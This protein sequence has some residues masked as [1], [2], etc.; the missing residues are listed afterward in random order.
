MPDFRWHKE[1][2]LGVPELDDAHRQMICMAGEI[3]RRLRAR[4][5]REDLA[6]RVQA[7]ARFSASHFAHEE[8]LMADCGYESQAVHHEQHGELLGQFERFGRRL[9][10]HNCG[11]DATKT[12]AF[13]RDWVAHHITHQDRKLADHLRLLGENGNVG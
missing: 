11:R 7:L 4:A 13:L 2:E 8:R 5:P 1:Y 9:L 3:A 6:A 10:S 12:L